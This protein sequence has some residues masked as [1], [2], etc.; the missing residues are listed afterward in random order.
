MGETLEDGTGLTKYSAALATAGVQIK[1]QNGQL[2]DMDQILTE[3]G[4]KW[5]TLNKD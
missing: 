2:K 4:E 5:D 3:L 1:D